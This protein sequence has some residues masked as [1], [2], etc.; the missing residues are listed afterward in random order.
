M[1]VLV[2]ILLVICTVGCAKHRPEHSQPVFLGPAT[3]ELTLGE[4]L[5]ML[6]VPNKPPELTVNWGTPQEL[7]NLVNRRLIF[8]P[9]GYSVVAI[10]DIE[11]HLLIL[12]DTAMQQDPA[13]YRVYGVVGAFIVIAPE[14]LVCINK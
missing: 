11:K 5:K 8:M 9:D 2:A 14:L 13:G 10:Y 4:V 1:K 12:S 7:T 3:P 6:P